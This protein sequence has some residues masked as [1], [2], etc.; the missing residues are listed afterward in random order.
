V[1]SR[2]WVFGHLF[3]GHCKEIAVHV[4]GN[5]YLKA[6]CDYVY[7]NPVRAGLLSP[8]QPLEA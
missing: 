6:V 7:L 2:F 1:T 5:G 8:E 4:S 3:S